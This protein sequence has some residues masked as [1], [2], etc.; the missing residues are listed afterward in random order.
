MDIYWQGLGYGTVEQIQEKLKEK[1]SCCAVILDEDAAIVG[2]DHCWFFTNQP[3]GQ[4]EQEYKND[5][6]TASSVWSLLEFMQE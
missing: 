3:V 1:A 5:G 2:A 6:G 4:A